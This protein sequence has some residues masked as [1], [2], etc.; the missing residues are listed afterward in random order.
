M[1]ASPLYPAPCFLGSAG[2]VLCA[3]C[4]RI[5]P[6]CGPLM[7]DPCSVLLY[8]YE[9]VSTVFSTLTSLVP[10]HSVVNGGSRTTAPLLALL[11]FALLRSAGFFRFLSLNVPVGAEH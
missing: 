8:D 2:L 10:I 9:I 7:V 6:P 5:G 3:V 1:L 11:T 4:R